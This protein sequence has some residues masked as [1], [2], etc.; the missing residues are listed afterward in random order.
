MDLM[1]QLKG[2]EL[3]ECCMN[4]CRDWRETIGGYPVSNH[5]PSCPNYVTKDFIKIV[6]KG[7][8]GPYLILKDQKEVDD[9]I[10]N[11]ESKDDYDITNIKLTEDQFQ[12][13]REFDGF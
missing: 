3:Q 7:Q 1:E 10:N 9:F 5:S 12:N 6:P 2:V 4:H 13:L 11:G 8:S